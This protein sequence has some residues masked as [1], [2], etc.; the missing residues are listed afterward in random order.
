M[1]YQQNMRFVTTLLLVEE[2]PGF[3]YVH[4]FSAANVLQVYDGIRHTALGAYDQ[5]FQ[6]AHAMGVRIANRVIL[7]D[8]ERRGA[9]YRT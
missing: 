5:P 4:R 1:R 9:R 6:V 3:W 7:V 8:W 2:P